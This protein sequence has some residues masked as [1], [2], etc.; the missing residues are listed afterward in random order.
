MVSGQM[1]TST[2]LVHHWLVATRGGER[3]LEALA[4]LFPS[5]DLF[6]LV[7]DKSKIADSLR[8][9]HVR[10][11]LLQNLPG[12]THWYRYYLPLFPF[13]TERMNLAG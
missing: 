9:R 1:G 10:S 7:C 12:A 6:T 4:E 8:S 2:A 11:S 13:A 5:A 3:V